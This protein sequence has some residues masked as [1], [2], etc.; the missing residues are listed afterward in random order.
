MQA[1]PCFIGLG[2]RGRRSF[3][4]RGNH[5]RNKRVKEGMCLCLEAGLHN[6]RKI[7]AMRLEWRDR[8]KKKL[9]DEAEM[10]KQ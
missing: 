10:E 2:Y 8:L 5:N 9:K 1:L 3:S 6:A 7:V 4:L